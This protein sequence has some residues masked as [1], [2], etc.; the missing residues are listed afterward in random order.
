MNQSSESIQLTWT[1]KFKYLKPWIIRLSRERETI[2]EYIEL[3]IYKMS[4]K[5]I[6][7][8]ILFYISIYLYLH[9]YIHVSM[10]L[11]ININIS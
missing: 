4:K 9:I 10:S 8:Y 3:Q 2:E 11:H 1:E 7:F 5:Y 6:Y